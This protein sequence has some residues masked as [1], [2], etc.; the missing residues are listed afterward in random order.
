MILAGIFF[1]Q[2]RCISSFLSTLLL[3]V[4]VRRPCREALPVSTAAVCSRQ[5]CVHRRFVLCCI[6]CRLLPLIALSCYCTDL[7]IR[8]RSDSDCVLRCMCY[9]ACLQPVK[10][11]VCST[12]Y[13][14]IINRL[15]VKGRGC[16]GRQLLHCEQRHCYTVF[17]FQGSAGAL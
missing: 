1:S 9:F 8:N 12:L 5:L 2:Y 13:A 17:I 3:G 10:C 16:E 7:G 4:V 6:T 15:L 11:V 14:Q